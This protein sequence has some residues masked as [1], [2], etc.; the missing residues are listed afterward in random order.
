MAGLRVAIR[1]SGRLP[2]QV[3]TIVDK[4]E[5]HGLPYASF[6][7]SQ[8]AFQ[9]ALSFRSVAERF[10][11]TYVRGVVQRVDLC[12]QVVELVDRQLLYDYAVLA[13]GS[14]S[15]TPSEYAFPAHTD[16]D[17]ERIKKAIIFAVQRHQHVP[18]SRPI[19]IAVVGGGLAGVTMAAQLIPTVHAMAREYGVATNRVRVV[20]FERLGR[21]LPAYGHAV[22]RT[23]EQYLVQLGVL[24]RC[25]ANVVQVEQSRVIFESGEEASTDVVVWAGAWRAQQIAIEGGALPLDSRGQVL[26]N[27]KF[28]VRAFP[29]LF[30]VGDQASSPFPHRHG[31]VQETLAEAEFIASILPQI[32]QNKRAKGYIPQHHAEYVPLGLENALR[33]HKNS[34]V[35]GWLARLG[36]RR[37]ERKYRSVLGM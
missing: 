18:V 5:R 17:V 30:C 35:T 28:Q 3:V 13:L 33:I 10:G 23:V 14:S 16:V 37:T 31:A 15:V 26:V 27:D 2:K 24:V 8:L 22:G 20:C 6:Q 36:L 21:L 34:A 7:G 25:H 9:N 32:M 29:N 1:L 12:K 11:F 4:Q 19:T